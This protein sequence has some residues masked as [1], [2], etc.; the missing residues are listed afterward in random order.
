MRCIRGVAEQ[1]PNTL[2]EIGRLREIT[3]RQAG[4]GTGRSLD[5]DRFDRD[6]QHLIPV[7]YR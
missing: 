6:Y 1:I 4:E 3:F 2:R 7:E 5:L